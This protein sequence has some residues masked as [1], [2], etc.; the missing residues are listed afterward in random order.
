MRRRAAEERRG[1]TVQRIWQAMRQPLKRKPKR[2]PAAPMDALHHAAAAPR[3]GSRSL[4]PSGV[5]G[6]TIA[7]TAEVAPLLHET[8]NLALSPKPEWITGRQ[9]HALGLLRRRAFTDAAS[10]GGFPARRGANGGGAFVARREDVERYADTLV[11]K[12]KPK[13]ARA[14][15]HKPVTTR[16]EIDAAIEAE[17]AQGLYVVH[18]GKK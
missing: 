2:K 15:P 10:A 8:C 12:P 4:C 7:G 1:L 16:E 11:V 3:D 18:G 6:C 14:A 17:L 13:P 9:A 5:S